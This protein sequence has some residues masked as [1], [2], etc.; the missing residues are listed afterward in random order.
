M[1]KNTSLFLIIWN[2]VLSALLGWSLLRSPSPAIAEEVNATDSTGIVKPMIVPRDTAALKEARIAYF[3]MDSIQANF[4]L[5]KE[6]S[7]KLKGE[8]RR[9]EGNLQ[10]K[11]TAAQGRYEELMRKDHTYSTQA[12]VQKDEA[13]LQRLAAE[14]QQLRAQS[15][16][17]LANMEMEVLSQISEEIEGYLEEYNAQAG[18]DYIFR[19]QSGGQIWTGNKGL[20]ITTEVVNGLNARHQQRKAAPKK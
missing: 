19:I 7:E 13:E 14:I 17:R 11:M 3:N 15:E 9:L 20:D 5:V 6:Q 8:G 2:V 4:L 10:S 16:S 18:F 1:S 12:D